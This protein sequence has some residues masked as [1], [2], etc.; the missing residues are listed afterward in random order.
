MKPYFY[1][2]LA[3]IAGI[4]ASAQEFTASATPTSSEVILKRDVPKSRPVMYN[5]LGYHV[6]LGK[7]NDILIGGSSIS[8]KNWGFCLTYRMGIQNLLLPN[9]RR[10]EITYANIVGNQWK[11]TTNVQEA[12]VFSTTA[13]LARAITRKIPIYAGPGIIYK[14]QFFEYIDPVDS[15]TSWNVNPGASGF[16]LNWSAGIF[17]PVVGRFL[18]NVEYNHNPQTIFVGIVIRDKLA[19]IDLDEW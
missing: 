15:L 18:L 16:K 19:Y 6:P 14:R 1:V 11:I 9:G 3:C 17:I 2:L 8:Y 7:A 5:S 13:C 4:H 10:G 12:T